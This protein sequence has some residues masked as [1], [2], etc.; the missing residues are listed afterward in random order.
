MNV[1]SKG[2]KFNSD[3][4]STDVF[5]PL[6][7]WH[8]TQVGRADRKLIVHA[9]NIRSHIA[10]MGLDYIEQNGMENAPHPLSHLI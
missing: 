5:I 2:I 6:A 7:G 8:R 4:Y 9:E 3:H 1:L 10:K